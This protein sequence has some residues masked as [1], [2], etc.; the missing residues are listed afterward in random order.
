MTIIIRNCTDSNRYLYS[1]RKKKYWLSQLH[2]RKEK[3]EQREYRFNAD[4][5]DDGIGKGGWWRTRARSRVYTRGKFSQN[6]MSY[7]TPRYWLFM[8]VQYAI[9]TYIPIKHVQSSGHKGLAHVGMCNFSRRPDPIGARHTHVCC[10]A[11][12]NINLNRLCVT[13]IDWVGNGTHTFRDRQ[14]WYYE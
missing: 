5:D 12:K 9:R 4:I 1:G 8:Y 3:E 10:I 2:P 14:M 13:I 11:N 7:D 6:C